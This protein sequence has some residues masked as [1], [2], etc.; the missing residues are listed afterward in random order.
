[1]QLQKANAIAKQAKRCFVLFPFLSLPSCCFQQ[2]T[3]MTA[4]NADFLGDWIG[5]VSPLTAN[6]RQ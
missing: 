1:M 6:R 5:Q 2:L 4:T 3:M